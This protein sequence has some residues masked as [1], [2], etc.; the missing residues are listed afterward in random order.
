MLRSAEHDA[1]MFPVFGSN[2]IQLTP[3]V[4]PFNVLSSAPDSLSHSLILPSSDEEA[5]TEKTGWNYT[6]V[7]VSLCPLSANCSGTRGKPLVAVASLSF[8]P[9][10]K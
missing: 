7:T 8:C 3:E 10:V 9:G 4:C 1:S 6:Q 2:A 5:T